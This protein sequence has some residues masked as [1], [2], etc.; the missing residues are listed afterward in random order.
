MIYLFALL[1]LFSPPVQAETQVI[2][3]ALDNPVGWFALCYVNPVP[4]PR[5]AQANPVYP[6][7]IYGTDAR[8]LISS[9]GGKTFTVAANQPSVTTFNYPIAAT[10]N[11]CVLWMGNDAGIF[12]IRRTCNNAG[13]W[14]TVFSS[15]NLSGSV[16]GG[17]STIQCATR[18]STCIAVYRTALNAMHTLVSVD[19]GANWVDSILG[20]F[21]NEPLA[22]TISSD[23]QYGFGPPRSSLGTVNDTAIIFTGGH[24]SRSTVWPTT[25]GGLCFASLQSFGLMRSICREGTFNNDYTL[26]DE[27]GIVINNFSIP[28]SPFGSGTSALMYLATMDEANPNWVVFSGVDNTG[29]QARWISYDGGLNPLY[30]GVVNNSTVGAPWQAFWANGWAYMSGTVSFSGALFVTIP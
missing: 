4:C 10:S 27:N 3:G 6:Q 8:F 19:N 28:N 18:S 17:Q 9:D 14:A 29:K 26:R 20:T 25:T 23:G 12:L 7:F 13:S 1:L 22:L 2:G 21:T 11:G 24:F 5:I 15:A 30:Q 16:I